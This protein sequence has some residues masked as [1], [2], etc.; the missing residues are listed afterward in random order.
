[1]NARHELILIRNR[2]DLNLYRAST[3]CATFTINKIYW[4]V[5]HVT[6][7]DHSKLAML[8]YLDRKQNIMMPFRSWELFE[9][10]TLPNS[11]KCDWT[12]KTSNHLQRPRYVI[13]ALQ[14][15][16]SFQVAADNSLYDHC[17]VSNMKLFLNG[18]CYPYDN[19]STSFAAGNCHELYLHFLRVQQS[20]YGGR[21]EFNPQVVPYNTFLSRVMFAFDCSRADEAVKRG[22]I[23]V[24]V[25]MESTSNFP[26]NTAAYCLIISDNIITYSP[27]NGTIYRE[28]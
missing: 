10:S 8:K 2:S 1:M 15:N 26:A 7:A 18:V 16:R 13:V 14:T 17:D 24:R 27:F 11:S 4:K 19:L 12:V 9:Y 5:P 22:M 23:D 3:D 28:N 25:E 20:Y 21:E 6:L